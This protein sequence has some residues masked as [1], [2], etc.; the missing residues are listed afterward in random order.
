MK[1]LCP[2]QHGGQRLGGR[3]DDVVVGFLGREGAS[4]RLCVEPHQHGP[5][6]PG[7]EA[8][9]HDA[10]PQAPG[11][12]QLG[13]LLE[14]IDVGIPEKGEPPRKVVHGHA[15]LDALLHV[16]DAVVDGER[17]FLHRRG[18]G[19]ADMIAADAD[20]VPPGHFPGPEFHRVHHQPQS[21]GRAGA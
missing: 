21:W 5:R 3:P 14:K 20:G 10:G 13:D 1:G 16:G 19:L 7:L 2:A 18:P 11:S 9:L 17:Q 8:I 6:V 15:P 12:P 4:R